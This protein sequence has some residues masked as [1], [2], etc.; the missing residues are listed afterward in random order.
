MSG[1]HGINENILTNKVCNKKQIEKCMA[2]V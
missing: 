2:E 1:Y